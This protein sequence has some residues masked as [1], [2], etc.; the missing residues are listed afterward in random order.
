MATI[1]GV[2]SDETSV[3]RQASVVQMV[4]SHSGVA[5][6]SAAL[7]RRKVAALFHSFLI[8]SIMSSRTSALTLAAA[9]V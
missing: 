1:L 3:V 2:H 4:Y 6:G 7:S 5:E 9:L 8:R